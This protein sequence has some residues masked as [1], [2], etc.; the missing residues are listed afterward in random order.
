LVVGVLVGLINGIIVIR[1]A[2]PSLIVT[3]GTLFAVA[4]LMLF[5]F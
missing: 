4:G 5:L 3:M 2:V 1:T